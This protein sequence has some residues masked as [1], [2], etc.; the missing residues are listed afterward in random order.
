MARRWTYRQRPRRGVRWRAQPPTRA[1]SRRAG[2]GAST[3]RVVSLRKPR[4]AKL[5]AIGGA[6]NRRHSIRLPQ[7]ILAA[8]PLGCPTWFNV[9]H[10]TADLHGRARR[11]SRRRSPSPRVT[12]S[13]R[14]RWRRRSP[15]L[16]VRCRGGWCNGD[17]ER[18]G[19]WDVPRW[20]DT[21]NGGSQLPYR[22]RAPQTFERHRPAFHPFCGPHASSQALRAHAITCHGRS[23]WDRAGRSLRALRPRGA[24]P[25]C[26]FVGP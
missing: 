1:P 23:S 10:T 26:S 7:A 15:D 25:S 24:C 13:R 17:R 20:A 9:S 18:R 21:R 2:N 4:S 12:P 22:S 5:T 16:P 19:R 14:R 3:S 6:R 8:E 11:R